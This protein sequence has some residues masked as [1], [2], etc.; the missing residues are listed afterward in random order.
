V[1]FLEDDEGGHGVSDPL[2]RPDVMAARLTFLIAALM[3]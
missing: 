1:Y 3:R 2:T